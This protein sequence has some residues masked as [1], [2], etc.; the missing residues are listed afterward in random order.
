MQSIA[1]IN[2]I[3]S[4]T[5]ILDDI[6]K[7]ALT[8]GRLLVILTEL[9]AFSAF[10]YRFTLDRT[11]IDLHDKINQEQAIVA[12]LKDR[13]DVYRNLQGRIDDASRITEVGQRNVKILNDI[14]KLTPPEIT[15][16]SFMIEKNLVTIEANIASLS[17]LTNFL[18]LLREYP[19]ISSVSLD[20][21]ENQALTNSISVLITLNLKEARQ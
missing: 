17:S 2:L 3:K 15:F 13:E 9:V 6:L 10:I 14:A 19:E 1:S 7:W 5:N 16:T 20:R 12:S 21:I 18:T 4:R 8:V 11:L